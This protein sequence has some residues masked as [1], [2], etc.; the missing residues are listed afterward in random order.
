MAGKAGT[1]EDEGMIEF[2]GW[3][4]VGVIVVVAII[5]LISLFGSDDDDSGGMQHP[6]GRL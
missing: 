6:M 1:T 3:L 4:F 5:G 2:L